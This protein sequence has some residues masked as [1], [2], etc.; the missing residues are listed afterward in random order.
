LTNS[1]LP[2]PLRVE[3]PELTK[4]PQLSMRASP[5]EPQPN[6]NVFQLPCGYLDE[7]GGR[8][9][10]AEL[11]P[12]TG[13]VEYLLGY[14]ETPANT[15]TL[16]TELLTHSVKRIGS[17]TDVD[18]S[19]IRELLVDD[20]DFLTIK[21]RVLT[22][23]KKVNCVLRCPACDKL[24]DL[25]LS[26]DAMSDRK[27]V[28]QRY[29]TMQLS[30]AKAGERPREIEFRLPAGG[31]QEACVAL[32]SVAEDAAVEALLAR[33]IRRIDDC[34]TVNASAIQALGPGARE[35]IEAQ[36]SEL[37]SSAEID[38]EAS[39][40]EC[41]RPFSSRLD[42]VT[43]FLDELKSGFRALESEIHSLAWHYH[44]SEQEI[45]SLPRP[46]RKRYVALLQ[47]EVDRL[48]QVW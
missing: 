21:L 44:W 37:G 7:S 12:L 14:R 4:A 30:G 33:C 5:G 41:S 48:N 19:L 16:V 11:T 18:A 25:T 34:M 36:M 46:R 10:E 29:F 2:P 22:F 28:N 13:R 38:I 31:D 42:M 47:S 39:C 15:A 3:A 20:R 23:G 6:G 45:L 24:M 9:E 35:E 8:H 32:S 26:L 40:P 1:P 43:F 27:P 17:L